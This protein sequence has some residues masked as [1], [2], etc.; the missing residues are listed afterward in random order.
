MIANSRLWLLETPACALRAPDS[1]SPR[2]ASGP[3]FVR[4]VLGAGACGRHLHVHAPPPT[5]RKGGADQ[6]ACADPPDEPGERGDVAQDRCADGERNETSKYPNCPVKEQVL[7]EGSLAHPRPLVTKQQPPPDRSSAHPAHSPVVHVPPTRRDQTIHPSRRRRS[8]L[9][10]AILESFAPTGIALD[11][12]SRRSAGHGHLLAS[13][14]SGVRVPGAPSGNRQT[15]II[16]KT[17]ARQP[18]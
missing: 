5:A 7:P 3:A 10:W 9:S 11:L 2:A 16:G 8:A 12:C 4:S 14:G 13:R 15:A 1:R 17:P 6:G 18:W